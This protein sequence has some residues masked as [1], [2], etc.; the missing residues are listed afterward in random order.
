[1]ELNAAISGNASLRR[2][3]GFFRVPN[4]K[5]STSK[6]HLLEAMVRKENDNGSLGVVSCTEEDGGVVR[7]KIVVKKS[8]LKQLVEVM[9]GVKGEAL[10]GPTI[11]SVAVP[12]STVE[13][14]LNLLWKKHQSGAKP[15]KRNSHKC[16]SSTLQC[17]PEEN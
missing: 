9:S 11:S 7:M 15:L 12:S 17:I 4:S 13:Q 5:K 2:G 16:W 3:F 14:R 1:M 6:H 10:H 8:D